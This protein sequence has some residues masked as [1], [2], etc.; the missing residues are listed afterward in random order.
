MAQAMH[1]ISVI[2]RGD[3]VVL[4]GDWMHGR[5]GEALLCSSRK[6]IVRLFPNSDWPFTNTIE[7]P[8]E[9][10]RVIPS[11]AR[12]GSGRVSN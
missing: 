1:P 8:R 11:R 6:V 4:T 10:L 7:V 3:R 2:S 9:E 5:I 12:R